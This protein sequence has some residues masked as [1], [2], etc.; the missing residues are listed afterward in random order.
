M[1]LWPIIVTGIFFMIYILFRQT[2]PFEQ[3]LTQIERF[4]GIDQKIDVP[5]INGINQTQ[6]GKN[7]IIKIQ[8][9][10]TNCNPNQT[11][12]QATNQNN[13]AASVQQKSIPAI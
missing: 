3:P 7:I 13:S 1:N 11:V 12:L 8:L 9:P 4:N 6:D 10:Y 2:F 5:L